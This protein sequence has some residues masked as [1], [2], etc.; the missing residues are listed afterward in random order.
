MPARRRASRTTLSFEQSTRQRRAQTLY[1]LAGP[2]NGYNS[3]KPA[4]ATF[5]ARDMESPVAK[6][7]L[8][9]LLRNGP[10]P[11]CYRISS[12]RVQLSHVHRILSCSVSPH[13]VL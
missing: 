9:D 5:D 2:T 12:S 3:P 11:P 6:I 10:E 1:A 13:P 7:P 8:A 4:L